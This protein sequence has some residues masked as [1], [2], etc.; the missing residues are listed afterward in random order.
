MIV[1]N[2]FQLPSEMLQNLKNE[3]AKV[4]LFINFRSV[5]SLPGLIMEF[6]TAKGLNFEGIVFLPLPY[7]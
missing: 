6:V 3:D 4:F 2:S 1:T 7:Y 5:L